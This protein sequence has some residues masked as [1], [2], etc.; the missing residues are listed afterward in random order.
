MLQD[1]K[2]LTEKRIGIEMGQKMEL[3]S[4]CEKK[5]KLDL[6][7]THAREKQLSGVLL[8]VHG[9]LPARF[10]DHCLE[11]TENVREYNYFNHVV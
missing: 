7:Y 10:Q 6:C 1:V 8:C 3:P 4:S 5:I 9:W 11:Y 2:L